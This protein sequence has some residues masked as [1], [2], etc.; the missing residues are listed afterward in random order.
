MEVF[1]DDK[2]WLTYDPTPPGDAAPKSV[3]DGAH[4]AVLGLLVLPGHGRDLAGG[5]EVLADEGRVDEV[6]GPEPGLADEAAER[7]GPP[8]PAGAVGGEGHGARQGSGAG[9]P[10]VKWAERAEASPAVVYSVATT[11]TG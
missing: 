1:I 5:V 6:V 4:Q 3:L 11:A 8:H 9:V 7:R 2:G 10:S